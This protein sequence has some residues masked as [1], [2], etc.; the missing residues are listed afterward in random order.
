MR[1]IFI[2]LIVVLFFWRLQRLIGSLKQAST[3]TPSEVHFGHRKAVTE[4]LERCTQC[5]VHF[6]SR[7]AI[8]MDDGSYVC[9]AECH[10]AKAGK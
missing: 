8:A 10:D 9:S 2:T 6:P 5:G 4:T 7:L 1:Y 3:R